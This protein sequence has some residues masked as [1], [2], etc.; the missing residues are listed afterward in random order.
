M[1][2]IMKLLTNS[3]IESAIES[4]GAFQCKMSP[5]SSAS[6]SAAPFVRVLGDD[7][8]AAA[9]PERSKDKSGVATVSLGILFVIAAGTLWGWAIMH[10][11]GLFLQAEVLLL[12]NAFSLS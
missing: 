5:R 6:H 3:I 12:R 10:L 2:K 1:M 11:A 9:Q 7:G 4:N 8:D